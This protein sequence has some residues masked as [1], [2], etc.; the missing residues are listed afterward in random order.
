MKKID[1]LKNATLK[2]TAEWILRLTMAS[3]MMGAKQDKEMVRLFMSCM[4]SP[5]AR[6]MFG[7]EEEYQQGI[8]R[9]KEVLESEAED[10]KLSIKWFYAGCH[11]FEI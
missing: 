8:K 4:S 2:E 9:I 10:D 11:D 7:K 5:T 3:T 1:V 6:M